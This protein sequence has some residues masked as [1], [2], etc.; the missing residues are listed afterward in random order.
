MAEHDSQTGFNGAA[1]FP[2]RMLKTGGRC[3]GLLVASMGPR[4]F[5]RGCRKADSQTTSHGKLQWGRDVSVAD[6]ARLFGCIGELSQRFN[7]AATFPSRMS[8]ALILQ[9]LQKSQLQWGRDVS[10]ADVRRDVPRE[11]DV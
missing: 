7:G 8:L 9:P 4:R 10:V 5:R 3:G 2:S 11:E 1:T 6:V